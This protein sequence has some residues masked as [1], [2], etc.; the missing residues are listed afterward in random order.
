MTLMIIKIKKEKI[1]F[2]TIFSSCSDSITIDW[3]S[4]GNVSNILPEGEID[5]LLF[6]W[7][8]KRNN[9]YF[10]VLSNLIVFI[11]SLQITPKFNK[12]ALM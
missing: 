3:Y 4:R 7:L 1:S 6:A 5:A 2:K 11:D 9:T 10:A 8:F 12:L